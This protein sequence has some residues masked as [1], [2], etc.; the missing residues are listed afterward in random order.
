VP[1]DEKPPDDPFTDL[2]TKIVRVPKEEIEERERQYEGDRKRA[3]RSNAKPRRII[4]Q[5]E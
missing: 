5:S 2:L 3:E 1:D 4:P